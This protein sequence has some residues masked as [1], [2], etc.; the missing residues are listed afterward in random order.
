LLLILASAISSDGLGLARA[1]AGQ[2]GPTI[3]LLLPP[4]EPEAASL[5]QGVQLAVEHANQGA[6]RKVSLVIR[7]RVG[8][9]GADAVEAARMVLDDGAEGLIAP[10][11]GAAT[12]LALQVSGR[13]AVPIVSLCPDSSVTRAGIPWM[14]RVAPGTIEEARTVFSGLGLHATNR[15]VALVPDGRAGREVSRDLLQAA[16]AAGCDAGKIIQTPSSLTNAEALTGQALANPPDAVLLWLDPVP[17]G[18]LAKG[19]RKAGFHG[20]IAGPSRCDSPSFRASAAESMEG[21][22][23]PGIVP[24]PQTSAR[25]DSFRKAFRGRFGSEADLTAAQSYDAATLLIELLKRTPT[26]DLPKAFPLVFS[27]PGVTGDLSFDK[28]GNRKVTL[29][30]LAA[31]EGRFVPV[32][33]GENLIKKSN[34]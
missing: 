8:Q 28:Y 2:T 34:R 19:L 25:F 15:W 20:K 16:A 5:G 10:P 27:L 3:G 22:V 17:A 9:W 21:F 23:V 24:D 26:P 11:S 13:T 33:G 1:T 29:R 32:G 18:A 6:A 31:R 7:G 30:L 4:E 12:H 14:L